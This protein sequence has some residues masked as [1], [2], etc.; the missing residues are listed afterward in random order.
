VDAP[1]EDAYR[2]RPYPIGYGQTISQPTIVAMMSQALQLRGDERVLEIGTGSGY[3]AA[4]LSV[5]A[6]E[7]YSIELIAP[8]AERAARRLSSAGCTNVVLRTGDGYA[9]WV[10]EA[11]FDRVIVT[12]APPEIPRALLL[13]LR[14]GGILVAPIGEHDNQRLERWIRKSAGFSRE[15]LGRVSFVPM[16][17]AE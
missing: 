13:Q 15:D 7:V 17:P 12:A 9:G 8:L 2:D 14:V 6:R 11:P 4:V 16:V 1:L 10:E 3:Q 5:L